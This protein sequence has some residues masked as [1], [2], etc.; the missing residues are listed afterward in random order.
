MKVYEVKK[1]WITDI[2]D[3][4]NEPIKEKYG[5]MIGTECTCVTI[6]LTTDGEYYVDTYY[7]NRMYNTVNPQRV[8]IDKVDM[9]AFLTRNGVSVPYTV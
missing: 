8:K 9:E 4:R 2:E 1:T 6:R 5:L 3:F 7:Y